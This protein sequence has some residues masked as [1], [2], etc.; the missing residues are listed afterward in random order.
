MRTTSPSLPATVSNPSMFYFEKKPNYLLRIS[1]LLIFSLMINSVLAIVP[2]SFN[3]IVGITNL[4]SVLLKDDVSKNEEFK[5]AAFTNGDIKTIDFAAAESTTYD[6]ATG[7]GIYGD[8]TGTYVVESLQGGDF[9]CGDIVTYF[10]YIEVEDTVVDPVNIV[11]LDFEFLGNTTGGAGV[12]LSDIVLVQENVGDFG[13]VNDGGSTVALVQECTGTDCPG[14][15]PGNGTLYDAAS[16]TTAVVTIDDLEAGETLVVRIDVLLSCDPGSSPTGNLQG[17]LA[18]AQA[19][20]GAG[21]PCGVAGG[22]QTIPFQQLG[23]LQGAGAG[24]LVLTKTVTNE[25]GTCG[26]DDLETLTVFAGETVKYCYEVKNTG[27]GDLFDVT[28][29]TDDNG[30]PGN[31]ADDFTVTLSGL[32]DIDGDGDLG[33]LV[34]G[35]TATG[36]ALVTYSSTGTIVNIAS[37]SGKD[38]DK[39]NATLL[40]DT[41]DATVIVE[42]SPNLLPL[43]V[44]DSKSTTEDV[45]VGG[46]VLTNDDQGDAPATVTSNTAPSNG[47]VVVN[48]DGAY[49]YTPDANYCGTDNFDYTIT[50][51]NGDTS[52]ATVTI[53]VVCVNDPPVANPDTNTTPE[54]TT[55][56]VDAANGVLNNDTDLEGDTLTVTEFVIDG[57]TYTA[58]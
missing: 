2:K 39:S 8:G 51:N 31:T 41:D 58:G 25:T 3:E 27:T 48:S 10:A 44:D 34:S 43:A 6:H 13:N 38:D 29:I 11:Q 50:D 4:T 33:D 28:N 35:G 24:F 1:I 21:C 18:N 32:T 37:A 45:A 26:V 12:A 46:N 57:N 20:T 17:K 16:L 56:T 42:P 52:S 36:T 15:D 9:A 53:D 49:T 5:A 40:T 47:T 14:T 55:L 30:T 7:G 22:V 19:L 23:Q 54:D